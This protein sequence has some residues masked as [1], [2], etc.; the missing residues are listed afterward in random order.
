MQRL[1]GDKTVADTTLNIPHP[2]EDGMAEDFAT[3]ARQMYETG[4]S[5]ESA[6]ELKASKELKPPF[7]R[8]TAGK[9]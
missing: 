1:A 2:Y 9:E 5:F 7:V 6:I 8:H 4:L 3:V